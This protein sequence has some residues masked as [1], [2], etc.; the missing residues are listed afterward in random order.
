MLVRIKTC[1]GGYHLEVQTERADPT[2]LVMQSETD[3][4]EVIFNYADLERRIRELFMGKN[5]EAVVI[6]HGKKGE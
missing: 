3:F 4:E 2:Y 5:C 6:D 1:R